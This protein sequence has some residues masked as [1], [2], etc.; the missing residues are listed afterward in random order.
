V[1]RYL[2]IIFLAAVI[3][4]T[5]SIL[6]I[7]STKISSATA[8]EI[9]ARTGLTFDWFTSSNGHRM[10]NGGQAAE[11]TKGYQFSIP[12]KIEMDFPKFSADI[13]TG[14]AK[15]QFKISDGEKRSLADSLD[16][17]LNLAYPVSGQMPF[18][19][20]FDILLGLDFNLPTGRTNLKEKDLALLSGQDLV[21]ITTF[22]EGLNINPT[23]SL[24]KEWENLSAGFGLGYDWRG[25]YDYSSTLKEYDPGDIVNFT[26]QLNYDFLTNYQTRFFADYAYFN[27][28][29][30]KG[31]D[32]FQESGFFLLGLG[33]NYNQPRWDVKADLQNILRGKSK[34]VKE[35]ALTIPAI[36]AFST[37]D[38]NSHG[39]EWI[40][41]LSWRY[42]L[43]DQTSLNSLM[44][45]L[46]ADEN[47]YPSSNLMYIGKKQKLS[48]GVGA[49][50][51]IN[52]RIDADV[53]VKG[54]LLN[55]NDRNYQGISLITRLTTPF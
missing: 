19:L 51:K 8:T 55:Q 53:L 12:V 25:K 40:A 30:V 52:T 33:L 5:L 24:A 41:N 18:Q 10:A 38:K 34:L 15:T 29:K 7:L 36:P 26:T 23:I 45:F 21:S 20:P 16:T 37:E 3:L 9:E 49:S 47:D 13:L 42:S 43:S 4:G 35:E 1:K 11:A 17:K 31:E 46:W 28:D 22:G 6:T 27:K 2:V 50:R 39:D 48:L 14:F 32:Y 44:G 54:F